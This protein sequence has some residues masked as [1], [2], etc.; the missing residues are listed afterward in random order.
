[1]L[2]KKIAEKIKVNKARVDSHKL[3][4]QSLFILSMRVRTSFCSLLSKL[5]M[6]ASE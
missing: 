5:W 4:S 6:Q 2:S 1:M 3:V